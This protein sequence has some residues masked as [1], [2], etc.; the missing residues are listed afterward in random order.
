MTKPRPS[1][2]WPPCPNPHLVF[3]EPCERWDIYRDE[4]D[5]DPVIVWGS[6]DSDHTFLFFDE[7]G[8]IVVPDPETPR[9]PPLSPYLMC[10]LY[11]LFAKYN[12]LIT[13]GD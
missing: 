10:K 9:M 11:E 2:I 13:Q 12:T 5:N 6:G 4:R 1:P 3:L 7:T 8:I